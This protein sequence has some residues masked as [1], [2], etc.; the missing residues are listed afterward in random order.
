M[1]GVRNKKGGGGVYLGVF[2]IF[3]LIIKPK[4]MIGCK[5]RGKFGS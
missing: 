2:E 3:V 1:G 5:L 4:Y